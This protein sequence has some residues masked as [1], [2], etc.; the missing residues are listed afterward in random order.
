M[1]LEEA[2]LKM[3]MMANMES[4]YWLV[5]QAICIVA[6]FGGLCLQECLNLVVEKMVHNS[7]GYSIRHFRVKQSS[8][9][10]ES[11]FLVPPW[12]LPGQVALR[13]QRLHRAASVDWRTG[14]GSEETAH[15]PQHGGK[16]HA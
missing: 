13:P 7:H 8:D 6:F 4:A 1:I 9:T 12:H 14:T 2:Q 5:R 11:V 3:F 15:R 16:G 10:T